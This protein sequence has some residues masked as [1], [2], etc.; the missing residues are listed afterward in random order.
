MSGR[1]SRIEVGANGIGLSRGARLQDLV[2]FWGEV[3]GSGDFGA[4]TREVLEELER[5]TTDAMYGETPD[6][7]SAEAFTA[8]AALRIAGQIP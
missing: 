2:H 5:Q 7:M 6:I 8:E 3:W 1:D 4:T